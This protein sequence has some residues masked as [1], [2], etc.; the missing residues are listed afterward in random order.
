MMDLTGFP[1]G[2]PETGWVAGGCRGG[3]VR[4][5]GIWRFWRVINWRGQHVDVSL[6]DSMVSTLTYQAPS[7]SRPT[8]A[9]AWVT[10]PSIVPYECFRR[11]TVSCCGHQPEAVAEFCQAWGFRSSPTIP[12]SKRWL[13]TELPV[14]DVASVMTGRSN[15][16]NVNVGIPAGP[17][18]PS[19]RFS[20][21]RRST[22]ERW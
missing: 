15:D 2:P 8:L 1:D 5:W 20:K 6:L 10:A 11:R 17:S 16:F 9:E 3:P 12:A 21:I 4:V 13:P 18:I 14:I 7:I 19:A 22:R